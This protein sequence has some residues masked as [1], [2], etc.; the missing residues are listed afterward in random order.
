M[1]ILITL[2]LFL[3]VAALINHASPLNFLIAHFTTS[4]NPIKCLSQVQ[5]VQISLLQLMCYKYST[6]CAFT[7]LKTKLYYIYIYH[8]SDYQLYNFYKDLHHLFW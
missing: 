7:R 3:Y 6:H 2:L 8:I 4:R 1:L 5:K